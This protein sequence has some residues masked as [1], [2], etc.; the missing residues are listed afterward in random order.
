M[1]NRDAVVVQHS[2]I[3]VRC[4]SGT[5]QRDGLE[6]TAETEDKEHMKVIK[7]ILNMD[8]LK[9]KLGFGGKR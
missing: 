7:Y 5:E 1:L 2:V 3:L 4:T 6:N 8:E 9:K